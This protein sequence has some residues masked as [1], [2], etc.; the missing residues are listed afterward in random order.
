MKES[1]AEQK[2]RVAAALQLLAFF[3]TGHVRRYCLR[4]QHV[5]LRLKVSAVPEP[6]FI[7]QKWQVAR[8]EPRLPRDAE[9]EPSHSRVF[10]SVLEDDEDTPSSNASACWRAGA[11]S[12]ALAH[13]ELT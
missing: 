3:R 5:G 10:P 9:A 13:P 4:L 11:R 1:R 8:S 6:H 12:A 7:R 2:E